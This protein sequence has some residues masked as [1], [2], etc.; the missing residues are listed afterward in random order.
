M[1]IF[2]TMSQEWTNH[3]IAKSGRFVNFVREP[4]FN[5]NS[6]TFSRAK[7]PNSRKTGLVHVSVRACFCDVMV[8]LRLMSLY[9]GIYFVHTR[10]PPRLNKPL[11]ALQV[12][13]SRDTLS[14][15][16]P[17][18]LT[19]VFWVSQYEEIGCDSHSPL[20]SLLERLKT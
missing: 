17:Y 2:S 1:T 5:L 15:V 11:P 7:P 14:A 19:W 13:C 9:R 18:L 10:P 20:F 3:R 16:A 6:P 8:C 4:G 12:A